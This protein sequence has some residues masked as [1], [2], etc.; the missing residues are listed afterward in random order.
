MRPAVFNTKLTK[1]EIAY[2]TRFIVKNKNLNRACAY[3]GISPQ[4]F[5]NAIGGA[6]IK[7]DQRRLLTKYCDFLKN[8]T[9]KAAA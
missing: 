9:E 8:Q 7:N 1:K 3:A 4:T 2:Y 6:P 5:S